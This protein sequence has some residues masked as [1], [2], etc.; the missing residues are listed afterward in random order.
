MPVL[1][2]TDDFQLTNVRSTKEQGPE[3]QAKDARA[4][5]H[6][7]LCV[8]SQSRLFH[9]GEEVCTGAHHACGVSQNSMRFRRMPIRAT[10]GQIC[11]LEAIITVA[12][13]TGLTTFAMLGKLAGKCTS[14]T[15]AS[16]AASLYAFHMYKQIGKFQ[17][18]GVSRL[19]ATARVAG[20]LR[21]EM[22]MWLEMRSHLNGA[23]WYKALQ[24]VLPVTVATDVSFLG[25]GGV[26][27]GPSRL[28]F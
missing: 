10:R 4:A 20:N 7:A 11:N 24:Q 14:M 18:T 8:F 13:E 19:S 17:R 2:W 23:A 22:K 25:C 16:P 6:L 3:Q 15:V 1:A 21:A 9:V 12:L 28:A 27:I 26:I 5:V